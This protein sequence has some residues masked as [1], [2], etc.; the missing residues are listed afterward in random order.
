MSDEKFARVNHH[1]DDCHYE[2]CKYCGCCAHGRTLAAGC[3]VDAA[4]YGMRC[5]VSDCGC[6][7]KS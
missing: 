3:K 4:P 1:A 7:G 6:E 5:P 2:Q